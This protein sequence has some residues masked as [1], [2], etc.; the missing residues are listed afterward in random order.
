[1]AKALALGLVLAGALL[2]PVMTPHASARR[3]SEESSPLPADDLSRVPREVRRALLEARQLR[4]EGEYAKAAGVLQAWLQQHPDQDHHL[5]RFQIASNLSSAGRPEEA[6][7]HYQAAV[8][9]EPRHAPSWLNLGAVAYDCGRYD[10]AGEAFA[11]GYKHSPSKSPEILYYAAAAFL[12]GGN[13]A[14]AA[15]LLADLTSGSHGQPKLDWY[16]ALVSA[17]LKLDRTA[18]AAEALDGMLELCGEDPAAW[19]LAYQVAAGSGDWR[20]AA[21]ALTVVGYLRP[22]SR[23]ELLQLGD[24]CVAIDAPA[25]GCA[26]YEQVLADSGSTADYERLSSAYLAAHDPERALHVL[27]R[28]LEQQPSARL[29]SLLGDLQYM[30]GHYEES[31]QAFC[32]GADLAGT[33]GRAYLMMGYCLLELRRTEEAVTCLKQ[34]AT[35]PS[36]EEKAREMLKRA[37]LP[38]P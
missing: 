25:W 38:R 18:E 21:V 17:Y 30:E 4:Q 37:Q 26:H 28:G 19:F 31:Y 16:Q 13:P 14:R 24:L 10:L 1:M 2:G 8:A 6:L 20:R 11:N 29:W 34:A 23:Q 36:Q 33:D 32:E 5:L 27:R 22:L 15:R 35:F 3:G 12:V 7:V 9:L